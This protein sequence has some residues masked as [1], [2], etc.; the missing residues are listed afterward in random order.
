L[1]R[2]FLG[3]GWAFPVRPRPDG[4]GVELTEYEKNIEEC[5]HIVL[6]TQPGERPMLPEFGCPLQNLVFQSN[7]SRTRQEAES[8]VKSALLKWEPRVNVKNVEARPDPDNPNQIRIHI[9]YIVRRSNNHQ[10][11]VH[12]VHLREFFDAD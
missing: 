8:M 3:R 5:I 7:S 2:E 6:N 12:L 1:S 10:N 4:G 11:M 9:D